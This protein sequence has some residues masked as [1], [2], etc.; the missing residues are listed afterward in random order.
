MIRFSDNWKRWI[1]AGVLGVFCLSVTGCYD[2][3][4]RMARK[5]ARAAYGADSKAYQ[6][7]PGDPIALATVKN[8]A[9]IP[10]DSVA[11]Q[12]GFNSTAFTTALASQLATRGEVRVFYPQE[13]MKIT[14]VENRKAN[15]HNMR[16]QERV[17]MGE[18]LSKLSREERTRMTMLDP[19]HS[20]DDAVKV[21]RLINA[22]AVV[23][24]MITDYDPYMRPKMCLTIKVVATGASDVA[25]NALADL[26]QW[27]VPRSATTARGIVW[28]MQQNFDSRDSD[29]GRN[30][31]VYGVS[32]HTED[33]PSDV[34]SYIYSM[35]QYYDYVGSVLARSMM[36]ARQQAVAEAE[37]RALAEAQKRQLAQEGVRNKIRA[38]TDPHFEVPNA[39]AVMNRNLV[40]ERDKGWRPD[41]YNIQ[42]PDKKQLLNTYVDPRLVQEQMNAMR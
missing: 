9:F 23:M 20:I 36:G 31:W 27:G 1:A 38:L 7:F 33:R 26:S 37:A 5:S 10:F 17:A 4:A 42:H 29:I 11:P 2:A 19:I 30:V 12:D 32:K 24:G 41:V 25:A 35:G 21:G 15:A 40:D 18:D 13:I 3:A 6:E 28:Y 39:D 34:Q 8:I 14:E 16:L 22:D